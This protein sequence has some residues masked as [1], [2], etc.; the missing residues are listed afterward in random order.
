MFT[1]VVGY[2]A[3]TSLDER[4][5][6]KLVEEHRGILRGAFQRYG[7]RVVKTMGDGFLVEFASAV[8]AVDSAVDAQKEMRVFNQGRAADDRV[9]VR[10]GIHVGDVVHSGKDV[11][12]DAV[13]VASRVQQLAEPGGVCVTRQ[14][15]DQIERKVDYK[16]LRMGTR[17]LK[18]IQYPIEVYK[19]EV[20]AG[21]S[22]DQ[23]PVFDPRR[24]AILPLVNLSADPS[25]RYFVDGMTE[26]LI[27]TV[28]NINE[29]S[30]ISRTS[31]M[32][33]KD[34]TVPIGE[35]GR[36]LS[37]GTVLEGSVRKAGNK[38]RITTQLIDSRNDKHLWAQ[39]YDRDLTD[40]FAIQADIAEQ[41]A[42]SLRVKLISK[43]KDAIE[44]KAT[45][46]PEAYTLYLK[47][48]YFWN[49]R[50]PE[51]LKKAIG[52][53]EGAIRLD[54]NFALAY[55]GLADCY[56]IQLDRGWVSYGEAGAVAKGYAEKAVELGGD[57]AEAHTSLALALQ[58]QW[59]MAGAERELK[60]AIELKPNYA[61][62][63]HWY[64]ST[65]I[66]NGRL[67]EAFEHEKRAYQLDPFSSV[68]SQGIGIG[69]LYM[70]RVREAIAQFEKL[71]EID[72]GFASVHFWNAWAHESVGE[73][74]QAIEEAKKAVELSGRN[75]YPMTAL[76]SLYLRAGNRE[77][78]IRLLEEIQS[79]SS[80]RYKSPTQLAM[81]K[82]ELGEGD[83]A[84]RLLQRAYQEHDSA[85]LY[86]QELPWLAKY[87]SDP[88][89][90]EIERKMW[91]PKS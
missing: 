58:M 59:D 30:V 43:E 29:L 51:G 12:G 7:G 18:N 15:L 31:V 85:L 16:L 53:F 24:I 45:V 77:P 90:L 3:I 2:S 69:L 9:L 78:A 44:K 48:R 25:D 39:S 63:H 89:W 68:V 20:P 36:E 86:F 22:Q 71:A 64:W 6:L 67:E 74:D 52:Y 46:N 83:E 23:A 14:V 41:V 8:E 19:V 1:D 72:P 79:D 55:S 84:I 40:I 65:L 34:S 26:E 56:L 87:R 35:I 42:Q 38:V 17:E 57:L 88:R 75:Y 47:G 61:T 4:R 50:S 11:L 54:P 80:G 82:F 62:A 60:R 49:E 37:A 27:S 91:L 81:I 66:H 28:S 70:G 76:A 73:Y 10:I 32:R 33:Y 13:N 21:V 5:A